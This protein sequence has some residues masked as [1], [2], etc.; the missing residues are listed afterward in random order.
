LVCHEIW[1]Q[2]TLVKLHTFC[3]IK[4]DT[5]SV[6]LFN[7]YDAVFADFVDRIGNYLADCCIACRDSCNAGDIALVVNFFGLTLK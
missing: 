4:F 6:R 5:K 2:I 1:R 3:E 7:S